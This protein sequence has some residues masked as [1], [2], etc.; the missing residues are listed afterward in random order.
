MIAF[1]PV[2]VRPGC[3]RGVFTIKV[4]VQTQSESLKQPVRLGDLGLV[5]HT[6]ASQFLCE[7]LEKVRL[8]GGVGQGGIVGQPSGH[9]Q[10]QV[11]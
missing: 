10:E 5:R 4:R 11:A 6:Q 7:P 1:E 2:Q 8:K 3:Q 9:A